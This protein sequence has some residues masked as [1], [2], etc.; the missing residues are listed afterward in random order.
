MDNQRSQTGDGGET[1]D[2]ENGGILLFGSIVLRIQN[3]VF[4]V[5]QKVECPLFDFLIP[6]QRLRYAET[7]FDDF[8]FK[9]IDLLFMALLLPF[10]E[11][12]L[13]VVF[14][15]LLF[16]GAQRIPFRLAIAEIRR[17][18]ATQQ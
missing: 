16:F 3:V 6:T 18:T 5:H 11:H 13:I 4:C 7:L 8:A 10:V 17:G 1:I 12:L 2:R 15:G 14:N 9:L